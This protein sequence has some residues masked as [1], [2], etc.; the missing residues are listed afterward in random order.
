M[1]YKNYKQRLNFN[2]SSGSENMSNPESSYILPQGFVD[3]GE[4]GYYD[5][6]PPIMRGKC[7]Y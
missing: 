7:Y 5:P 6:P 1:Y 3:S 2:F 4:R